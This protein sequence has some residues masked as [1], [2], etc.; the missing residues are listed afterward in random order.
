M[1][2]RL[3]SKSD[4]QVDLENYIIKRVREIL[5]NIEISSSP[6]IILNADNKSIICPDFFSEK[7]KI[8]GEIHAHEGRLKSSQQDKIASDILK[9]ILY[10]KTSGLSYTKY[11]VVCG[12][13][14]YE[15][16][17]GKSYLAEAIREYGIILLYV[18]IPEEA[19][20]Q[21]KETMLK[22]DL[23]KV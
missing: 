16:L 14:E 2:K 11:I 6:T 22:Q 23:F 4:V 3:D 19:R 13:E 10:E 17:N 15:Q 1:V 9:M 12:K 21:L 20:M 5:G 18:E 7:E 8:I